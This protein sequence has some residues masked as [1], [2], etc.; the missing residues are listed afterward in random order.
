MHDKIIPCIN[1]KSE[2]LIFIKAML[3]SLQDDLKE[4][5]SAIHLFEESNPI[6]EITEIRRDEILT[7]FYIRKTRYV[8]LISEIEVYIRTYEKFQKENQEL[9]F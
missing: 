3:E 6:N 8:E 5:N 9:I 7:Q 1:N 4:V 2:P